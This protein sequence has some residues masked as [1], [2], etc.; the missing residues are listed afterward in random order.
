MRV[1]STLC[2]S[3]ALNLIGAISWGF[4]WREI[5]CCSRENAVAKVVRQIAHVVSGFTTAR[6]RLFDILLFFF[7]LSLVSFGLLCL[8]VDFFLFI[9]DLVGREEVRVVWRRRVER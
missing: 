4:A 8:L 9:E 7:L 6:V 3:L 1:L 5:M 2:A